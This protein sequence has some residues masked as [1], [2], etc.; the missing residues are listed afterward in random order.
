MKASLSLPGFKTFQISSIKRIY[1]NGSIEGYGMEELKSMNFLSIELEPGILEESY[2][3]AIDACNYVKNKD[4][5]VKFSV[6]EDKSILKLFFYPG[7]K[8]M[9]EAPYFELSS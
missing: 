3:I 1:F 7:W 8:G 6:T 5:Y 2:N 4:K 9:Q